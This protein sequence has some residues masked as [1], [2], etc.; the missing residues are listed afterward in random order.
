MLILFWISRLR[1]SHVMPQSD[2]HK[3]EC[4]MKAIQLIIEQRNIGALYEK[5]SQV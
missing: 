3:F 2:Q 5:L 4:S 1:P